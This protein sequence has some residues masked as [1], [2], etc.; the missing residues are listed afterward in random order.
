MQEMKL[1]NGVFIYLPSFFVSLMHGF[2]LL[3]IPLYAVD[4]GSSW[5]GAGLL[6][7]LKSAGTLIINAPASIWITKYGRRKPMRLALICITGVCVAFSLTLPFYMQAILMALFGASIGL[8]ML[9]QHVLLSAF[10]RINRRGRSL[11][12]IATTQR[13]GMLLGPFMAGLL[14]EYFSYAFAFYFA[15]ALMF[16]ATAVVCL[17]PVF[18]KATEKPSLP[19]DSQTSKQLYIELAALIRRGHTAFLYSSLFAGVLK[20]VRTARQVLIPLWGYHIGL[21]VADIGLVF[22]LSTA[23]DVVLIYFGGNIADKRGRKFTGGVC[24]A[25]LAASLILLPMSVGFWSFLAVSLMAGV[26]NGIGGGIIMTL[27][28][29]LAP[30][31]ARAMF[32]GTWRLSNDLYGVVSPVLIGFL[33]SVVSLAFSSFISGTLGLLGLGVLLF[34][35]SE[36]LGKRELNKDPND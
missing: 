2:I 7:T 6:F 30:K 18:S 33:A 31:K 11:S 3:I 32:I 28:A 9:G 17:S 25:L 16:F 34:K 24:I 21:S 5:L 29:D 14:I 19:E 20:F 35:T 36:T 15:A 1:N 8:W 13:L 23:A 12:L 26:G 22:S 27:G 4:Q 10:K